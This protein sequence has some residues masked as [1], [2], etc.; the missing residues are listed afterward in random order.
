MKLRKV[1]WSMTIISLMM[2]VSVSSVAI[3]VMGQSNDPDLFTY[4]T[5]GDSYATRATYYYSFINPEPGDTLA[6]YQ[7]IQLSANY[8]GY[9][10]YRV[11]IAVYKDG[12]RITNYYDLTNQGN[13]IWTI[14]WNT[15]GYS[16]GTGYSLRFVLYR[17][18]YSYSSLYCNDLTINNDGGTTP[19]P[20]PS[21]SEKIA[22][23]FWATDAGTSSLISK[24][25]GYLQDE[26]YTKFFNFRD[27]TNVAADCQS[28]DAYEDSDDTVFVYIIGHGNNDG[29]HSYT[30]FRPSGSFVYSNTF[31]SYMD[32][33][34]APRKC[35]LVESCHSGDWADDFRASPYL[36][37]STSDETHNSYAYSTLPGEGKFS[38][39]FFY[40]IRQG[41]SAVSAFNFASGYVSSPVQNPKIADY[42]T[43]S[44]FV[45]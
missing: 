40:R 25:I 27:S 28:V 20:P 29:Y 35:I 15:E 32:A 37:M 6:G 7:T 44:W 9:T 41:Y 39:Y 19:D 3:M 10:L 12:S 45:N 30:A 5:L 31:R 34:E 21:G 42:S 17:N 13:N 38:Y 22:V 18:Y 23:F 16:D 11:R 2:I 26:G 24:Y 14:N 43:Y 8:D 36:A 4:E 33:W 1:I